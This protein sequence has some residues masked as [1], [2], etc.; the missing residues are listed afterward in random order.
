MKKDKTVKFADFKNTYC[1]LSYI[2]YHTKNLIS[3]NNCSTLTVF[4]NATSIACI[5]V[6]Q[7]YPSQRPQYFFPTL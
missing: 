6:H 7:Q 4:Q 1:F 2:T 3:Q 5:S